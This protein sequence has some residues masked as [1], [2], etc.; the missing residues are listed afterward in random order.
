VVDSAPSEN[1]Y[2]EHFLGVKAAGAWGWRPHHLHVPNI[3]NLLQPSGPHRA[4]YGT[5]LPFFHIN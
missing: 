4:S 2:E 3:M 5:P 1:E